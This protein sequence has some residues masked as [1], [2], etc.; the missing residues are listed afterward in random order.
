MYMYIYVP[1]LRQVSGCTIAST[2]SNVL[3]R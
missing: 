3:G 1:L 2:R